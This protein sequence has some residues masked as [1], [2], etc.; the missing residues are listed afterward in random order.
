MFRGAYCAALRFAMNEVRTG[1]R[2]S[3][4][5]KQA[6]GWKL[7]LLI[8]RLLLHRPARRGLI[9][10]GR[11]RERFE[12][13]AQVRWVELQ[14]VSAALEEDAHIARSRRGRRRQDSV[15]IR[16]GRAESLAHLGELSAARAALEG[17]PLAQGD[18]TLG[19]LQDE[20]RRPRQARVPIPPEVWDTD[21]RLAP[22]WTA[23]GSSS[24]CEQP[25]EEQL[26][27]HLG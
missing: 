1:C 10:R 4:V 24:V 19:V 15:A 12:K 13:F 5:E 22:L 20:Q 6:R 9:P 3:N 26:G 16:A 2:E 21:Q 8:P 23:I 17:A 25:E 14:T 7:F 27:D 18:T 11:L